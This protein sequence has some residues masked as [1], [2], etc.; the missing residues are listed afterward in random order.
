MH[1]LLGR[2]EEIWECLVLKIIR[3]VGSTGFVDTIDDVNLLEDVW[4]CGIV[5]A[6]DD[7]LFLYPEE[8]P[9]ASPDNLDHADHHEQDCRL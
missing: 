3:Q 8:I 2:V 9:H 1:F 4:S 7:M 5:L 6:V